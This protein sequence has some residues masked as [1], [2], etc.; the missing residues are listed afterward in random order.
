VAGDDNEVKEAVKMWFASQAAS[1]YIAGIL[2]LVPRY[3]SASTV[4]A[5]VEK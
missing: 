3:D 2:K 5:T 1:Y 4:V